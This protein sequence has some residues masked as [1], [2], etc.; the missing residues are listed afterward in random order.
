[1]KNNFVFLTSWFPTLVIT[2]IVT[3]FFGGIFQ[4]VAKFIFLGN[5]S[6]QNFIVYAILTLII[7]TVLALK[8]FR[9]GSEL[10]RG[11][12]EFSTGIPVFNMLTGG[13]VYIGIFALTKGI[14]LGPL[15]LFPC[16]MFMTNCVFGENGAPLSNRIGFCTLQYFIY[17]TVSLAFYI[18]SKTKQENS[19]GVK[20][21]RGEKK[22]QNNRFGIDIDI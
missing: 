13:A 20:K 4:M 16:E 11:S 19:E 2:S 9:L 3:A 22:K 18:I 5:F 21:L 17:V 7:C 10:N 6:L 12:K 14:A 8:A 1:M 15:L